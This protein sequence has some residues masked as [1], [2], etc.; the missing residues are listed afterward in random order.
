MPAAR[1]AALPLWRQPPFA[2][3]LASR[4]LSG[5]ALQM[6]VVAVGWQVYDLT[7]SALALGFVGLAQFVPTLLLLPAA[8]LAADRFD[9]RVVV[10]CCRIATAI[11]TAV[12]AAGSLAGSVDARAIFAFAALIGTTRALEMPAQQALISSVA[13]AQALPRAQALSTS[14]TQ[15]ATIGGPAAGGLAYGLAGPPVVYAAAA[16][17]VLAAAAM[18]LA[19][20]PETRRM[21]RGRVT[22]ESL[23]GGIGFLRARP[24]LIGAVS[25]DLLAVLLGGAT[26]LLPIYA[27]DILHT[28]P[29]GLGL[30]RAA[31]AMG[32]LAMSLWLAWRP[33]GRQAGRSMFRAVIV[34]GAATVAFG[35]STSLPLSMLALAVLGGADVVSV[36]VRQS[37]VQLGTPDEMRG[38]V[39]AVNSVFIGTSNQLGEFESGVAA[40]LLGPVAAV[41]LGGIGTVVVAVLWMRLFPSLREIDR[42]EDVTPHHPLGGRAHDAAMRQASP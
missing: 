21:P 19:I 29:W 39:A 16:A 34:F 36:V 2:L 26:A 10:A 28:G 17:A 40:A 12:L 38:R 1:S 27:R 33:L 14:T 6:Q 42:L 31:P 15:F 18:V 37:L 25:L 3:F 30:L 9:R 11:A 13:T 4:L 24:A 22:L 35:L 5:L 23:L 41:V 20:P 32:A 7:D 8:G